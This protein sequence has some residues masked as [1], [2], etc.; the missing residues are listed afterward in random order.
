MSA[1][2]STSQRRRG[3]G[4][5]SGEEERDAMKREARVVESK[6]KTNGQPFLSLVERA[7]HDSRRRNE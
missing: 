7:L 6:D 3:I 2:S 1:H 4:T 5:Q